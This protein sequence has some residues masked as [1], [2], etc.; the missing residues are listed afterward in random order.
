MT[1]ARQ[2][3]ARMLITHHAETEDELRLAA[4]IAGFTFHALEALG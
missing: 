3:A 2:A 4:N 1:A